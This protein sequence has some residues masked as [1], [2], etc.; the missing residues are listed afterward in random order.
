MYFELDGQRVFAAGRLLP[1]G[2][3]PPVILVHGAAMDHSVWVYH[4]RYFMHVGR[5]VVGLDLPAHGRSGGEPLTS[6]EAQAAWL[7]RCLDTLGIER[8]AVA[9]HSMGALAALQLA[10]QAPARVASLALLGAAF[11]MA[12]SEQLLAAAKAEL[13]VARDMMMLWGHGAGAQIGSNPVAGIHIVNTAMRLLERARPGLLHNDLRACNDYAQGFEVA[14]AITARTTLIC[15]LD[16]K[17]TPPAVAAQLAARIAQ[18]TI[19]PVRGSGH[20][21]MSEQPEQT[22]RHLVAALA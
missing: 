20:I 2:S 22:H 13:P 8:A 3:A 14:P 16:D 4:T 12:V 10:G 15:G 17:M 18:C 19:S 11:P 7:L 6:I 21:M 9:G 1:D 5:A